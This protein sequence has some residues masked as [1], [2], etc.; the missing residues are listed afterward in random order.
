MT[1]YFI[2]GHRDIAQKEFQQHYA[3]DIMNA[4]L[5]DPTSRFIMGDYYGVDEM[6]Q[7]YLASLKKKYPDIDVVVYHMFEEPR[8]NKGDHAT[9]GGYQDDHD[10]DSAMT[11]ESDEDIAWVRSGKQDSGTA[12][13]LLRRRVKELTHGM[14]FDDANDLLQ[15]M[16]RMMETHPGN[17]YQEPPCVYYP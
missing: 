13:N 8:N 12:Q 9:K 6:A 3:K 10:R 4:V 1:T 17:E 5:K 7:E 15:G 2:S 14:K 16:V 11:L